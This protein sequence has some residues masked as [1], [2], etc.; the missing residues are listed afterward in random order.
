[1]N[2]HIMFFLFVLVT[3]FGVNYK[4]YKGISKVNLWVSIFL[5]VFSASI[6]FYIIVEVDVLRPTKVLEQV[7]KPLMPQSKGDV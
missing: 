3:L 5:V 1:M 2:N 7:L 4:A 6:W